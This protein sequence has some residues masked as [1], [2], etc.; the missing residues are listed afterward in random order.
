MHARIRQF[1]V[2]I[3]RDRI[4]AVD[5]GG[6]RNHRYGGIRV[7]PCNR[8]GIEPRVLVISPLLRRRHLQ[9]NRLAGHLDRRHRDLVLV[10]EILERPDRWPV[11]YQ[12]ERHGLHRGQRAYFVLG[13][14]GLVPQC[15]Q[16]R[17]AG[18]AEVHL[19]AQERVDQRLGA[20]QALVVRL[21][22][23]DAELAGVLLHELERVHHHQRQI[24]QAVLADHHDA[25]YLVGESG[26]HQ[27]RRRQGR[28][29][30]RERL[31]EAASVQHQNLPWLNRQVVAPPRT[32]CPSAGRFWPR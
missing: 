3:G 8:V 20:T 27:H 6:L 7:R 23:G 22:R 11:G 28:G 13:A 31:A 29:R 25:R 26:A 14:G 15:G 24:G 17:H 10:G 4:V 9:A 2:I 12:H 30:G 19:P 16:A 21:E 1:V 32:A 18:H 5:F